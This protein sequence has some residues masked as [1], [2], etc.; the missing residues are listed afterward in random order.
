M[1]WLISFQL[2]YDSLAD[3]L[4]EERGYDAELKHD[5]SDSKDFM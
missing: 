2:V 1:T 4:V 5:I 3:I